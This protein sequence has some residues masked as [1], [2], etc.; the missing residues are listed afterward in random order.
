MKQWRQQGY[1]EDSDDEDLIQPLDVNNASPLTKVVT[2]DRGAPNEP[3]IISARSSQTDV[4]D[5]D[6]ENAVTT[7][8]SQTTDSRRHQQTYSRRDRRPKV[9]TSQPVSCSATQDVDIPATSSGLPLEPSLSQYCQVQPSLAFAEIGGTALDVSQERLSSPLSTIDDGTSNELTRDAIETHITSESEQALFPPI[10]AA[11]LSPVHLDNELSDDAQD[12]VHPTTSA[13]QL[14]WARPRSLRTRKA[15]QLHPYMVEGERY[16]QTMKARGYRPVHIAQSVQAHSEIACAF[17]A[18]TA[19]GTSSES[20]DSDDSATNG[21]T[22]LSRA[23][24]RSV[25]ASPNPPDN[26]VWSQFNSDD[27]PD[28]DPYLQSRLAI[29]HQHP[30]KRRKLRTQQGP[31]AHVGDRAEMHGSIHHHTSAHRAFRLPIDASPRAPPGS[32]QVRDGAA[33]DTPAPHR[34][35]IEQTPQRSTYHQ[36]L[37]VSLARQDS[38]DAI[39]IPSS[40][41]ESPPSDHGRDYQRVR[42]MLKGVLPPSWLK[43]DKTRPAPKPS[44]TRDDEHGKDVHNAVRA[45]KGVAQIVRSTQ[46]PRQPPG[47]DFLNESSQLSGQDA[48]KDT[49]RPKSLPTAVTYTTRTDQYAAEN[50]VINVSSDEMEDDCVDTMFAGGMRKNSKHTRTKRAHQPRITSAFD[51][52]GTHQ[53]KSSTAKRVARSMQPKARK[54]RPRQVKINLSVLDAASNFNELGPE[55][56]QFLRLAAR[57][58]ER[59][60]S[61]ARQA[62]T[63]KLV[64]LATLADTQDAMTTLTEWR[65]GKLKPRSSRPRPSTHI[66]KKISNRPRQS[67]RASDMNV[68]IQDVRPRTNEGRGPPGEPAHTFASPGA[69][70]AATTRPKAW[71]KPGPV[72]R[73]AQ[74]ESNERPTKVTQAAL[75]TMRRTLQN[76]DQ[77]VIELFDRMLQGHRDEPQP[78]AQPQLAHKDS[79][80]SRPGAP[81]TNCTAPPKRRQKPKARRIDISRREVRQPSEPLPPPI[82]TSETP[83]AEANFADGLQDLGPSNACYSTSFDVQAF[84]KDVAFTP[85]SFL[86]SGDFANLFM[87]R[88]RDMALP[89]GH[90]TIQIDDTSVTLGPWNEDAS[91]ALDETKQTIVNALDVIALDPKDVQVVKPAEETIVY[92]LH[93]QVRYCSGCLFFADAV[94]GELCLS[95]YT[96]FVDSMSQTLRERKAS[97]TCMNGL[98]LDCSL[99]LLCLTQQMTLIAERETLLQSMHTDWVNKLDSIMKLSTSLA[100]PSGRSA[101]RHFLE[102]SR[103]SSTELIIGDEQVMVKWIVISH[104]LTTGVGSNKPFETILHEHSS[105]QITSTRSVHVLDQIWYDVMC[106]QPCLEFDPRGVSH[107]GICRRSDNE[108][109]FL[110]KALLQRTLDLSL[111]VSPERQKSLNSYLRAMIR[112]VQILIETWHWRNCAPVLF[113]IYDHFAKRGLSHLP[114]E[115]AHSSPAF[116]NRDAEHA[117]LSVADYG[118]VFQ[119]F[120]VLLSIGLRSIA[121]SS[122]PKQLKQV[123]ARL[124]PNH[125]RTYRKDE[126]VRQSDLDALRNHHD[127]LVTMFRVLPRSAQPR[128]EH[129]QYLV[130]V[131][132]SH[133]EACHINIAAWS[134][135]A[136]LIMSSEGCREDVPDLARWFA[137]V[138][139]GILSQF[140]LARSEAE[141]LIALNKQDERIEIVTYDTVHMTVSANQRLL[142]DTLMLALRAMQTALSHFKSSQAASDLLMGSSVLKVLDMFDASSSRTFAPVTQCLR[143][144]KQSLDIADTKQLQRPAVDESQE[145]G[146]WSGLDEVEI[147][148]QSKAVGNDHEVHLYS[149][150]YRLL[151]TCFGAD[152]RID[153]TLLTAL[154]DLW[155]VLAKMAVLSGKASW[156]DY[157][158]EHTANSWFQ[159]RQTEQTRKWTPYVL[160]KV[161]ET[162]DDTLEAVGHRF[163]SSWLVALLERESLLK[164]QHL[165]TAALLNGSLRSDLLHNLPFAMDPATSKYMLTLDDLRSRRTSLIG[166]ILCNM[167]TSLE[168]ADANLAEVRYEYAKML[169]QAM[170][171]MRAS[172]QQLS[173]SH[174]LTA[175]ADVRGS[176]VVFLQ[177]IIALMQ[178]YT[179]DIC[180]IDTFFTDSAAFPLPT[181]DPSYV[182]GRLKS[183]VPRLGSSKGRKQLV[184]FVSALVQRAVLQNEE[185]ALVAQLSEAIGYRADTPQLRELLL[186]A[187][188]PAYL[189]V[190]QTGKGLRQSVLV[191]QVVCQ[192]FRAFQLHCFLERSP[193][194]VSCVNVLLS[195]MASTVARLLT[196]DTTDITQSVS[197]LLVVV[198]EVA[199]HAIS[200]LDYVYRTTGSEHAIAGLH[201]LHRMYTHAYAYRHHTRNTLA[202]STIVDVEDIGQPPNHHQVLL[203]FTIQQ[204]KEQ[205]ER[206]GAYAHATPCL[207]SVTESA[208]DFLAAYEKILVPSRLHVQRGGQQQRTEYEEMYF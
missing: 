187:V 85:D 146:D 153:D 79:L 144:I 59:H 137:T 132:V 138:C 154:A 11:N 113:C 73:A 37:P 195:A 69:P 148:G 10:S 152:A 129:I 136:R 71:Y 126:S 40:D 91:Q 147:D 97:S 39:S 163:L 104:H 114:G 167:R 175:D 198:L 183:Y 159:M 125:G 4:Y 74:L 25:S 54:K 121:T 64:R 55:Q 17:S 32:A 52:I 60:P 162:A 189:M 181:S 166:S 145:Y 77:P 165:L 197:D 173:H 86:G 33:S 131:T 38:P 201:I 119:C 27:L 49:P 115:S 3:D 16:R 123:A 199:T 87:L 139:S 190:A 94:D 208:N 106:I 62:P 109:W 36:G 90:I 20:S 188:V 75:A 67:H 68:Q 128:L 164:F 95:A 160:A 1:V 169:R 191:L 84:D 30:A 88:K 61:R 107:V 174:G 157:L 177:H 124:I 156:T 7:K 180:P 70:V 133:Q 193:E 110:I 56:P 122:T 98:L 53:D 194:H 23:Q 81:V 8:L 111:V 92:L 142:V 100:L 206:P 43:L 19:V 44:H 58:A 102:E 117:D 184:I 203:D 161:L 116:L 196:S 78:Q 130:D 6:K 192:I 134:Q 182:V 151:S 14:E 118:I 143:I 149:P 135:V 80:A 24:S 22:M 127:L 28:I 66:S 176:H 200:M 179:A 31:E 99:Y 42:K 141:E 155:C 41:E 51:A 170:A 108:A 101:L 82:I 172:Y 72:F 21:L 112:R 150:I 26:N 96:R 207:Q 105:P 48:A 47:D 120:L 205:T 202:A 103:S 89:A 5:A 13:G 18:D 171:A 46:K 158:E 83:Q 140:N 76:R 35:T 93:S 45:G 63:D 29:P 186:L 34:G 2:D 168:R 178:Q 50:N 185:S 204:L 9:S 12:I 57:Q 15:I 65:S